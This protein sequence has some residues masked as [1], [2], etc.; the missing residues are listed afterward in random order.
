MNKPNCK[1]ASVIELLIAS[2]IFLIFT[3]AGIGLFML[4]GSRAAISLEKNKVDEEKEAFGNLLRPDVE[5]AGFG[6]TGFQHHIYGAASAEFRSTADYEAPGNGE[7]I[8]IS[9]QAVND[10]F[11]TSL[12]ELGSETGYVVANMP[13]ESEI[14][15]TGSRGGKASLLIELFDR[16]SYRLTFKTE[17]E[18]VDLGEHEPGMSYRLSL[19][20]DRD[21]K[22]VV[23]SQLINGS[24]GESS[25]RE[26]YRTAAGTP[27]GFVK[28]TAYIKNVRDRMRLQ[29]N[30]APLISRASSR[31]LQSL[32][33]VDEDT[34]REVDSP[35]YEST[36][37]V[38]LLSGDQKIGVGYL[39]DEISDLSRISVTHANGSSAA[40]GD[41]CLVIDYTQG[42]AALINVIDSYPE[43][44]GNTT[45]ISV[46]VTEESPAWNRFYNRE[47]ALQT[48]YPAGSRFIKLMPPVTY[49]VSS[50]RR[51]IRQSG[52]SPETLAFNVNNFVFRTL[53]EATG[54]TYEIEI[55]LA[56]DGRQ[57][58][59]NLPV[60]RYTYKAS[61]KALNVANQSE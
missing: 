1:G 37:A 55:E 23:V 22:A 54:L 41:Y 49:R 18:K 24:R 29:M 3:T 38:T 6:I 40:A 4:A 45:Y 8:R 36:G 52:E 53:P 21:G 2:V 46:P 28:A 17:T 60:V 12:T 57:T 20:P 34:G 42:T 19:T 35:V 43:A 59:Q 5:N 14:S 61:P 10:D 44:N 26:L 30:G 7:I 13:G 51:L 25:V 9:E 11:I 15:L 16:Q 50:D 56:S 27:Y 31:I 47:E 39:A 32:L 58:G 48:S 33:F